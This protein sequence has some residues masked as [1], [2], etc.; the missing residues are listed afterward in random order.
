MLEWQSQT[1]IDATGRI[2]RPVRRALWHGF[3]GRCPSCG[4]PGLFRAYLKPVANCRHCDEDLSHQRADD[5][6]P[7]FTMVI[8]GHIIVPI[9]L[10]VTMRTELS[11]LTHLAIWLPLALA[12]T[13]ALL[14]PVKGATIGL[15]WALY[16]HGFDG[17]ADPDATPDYF[18]PNERL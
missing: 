9:M 8:V 4:G 10:A 11:N 14:Q 1:A 5:A 6:P 17:S 2:A 3:R 12:M 16:M 13:L 7:Y 18:L 15:Q